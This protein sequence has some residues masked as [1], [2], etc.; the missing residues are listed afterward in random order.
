SM[1][2]KGGLDERTP[3]HVPSYIAEA[4]FFEKWAPTLELNLP[5]AYWTA[6]EDG[7][8]GLVLLENLDTRG[9]HYGYATSPITHVQ[10]RLAVRLLASLHA[11]H[12]GSPLLTSLRSYTD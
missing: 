12:W 9:A 7:R 4:I 2:L 5:R 10:A 8:Q 11:R 3:G 1:L 6:V